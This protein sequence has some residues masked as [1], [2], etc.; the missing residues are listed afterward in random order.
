VEIK[1]QVACN[2]V[3]SGLPLPDVGPFHTLQ[4]S[5]RFP[6]SAARLLR[7]FGFCSQQTTT[8]CDYWNK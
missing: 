5:W 8:C 3:D 4:A 6:G 1:T 7:Q 2:M